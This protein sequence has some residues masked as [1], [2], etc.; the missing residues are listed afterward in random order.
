MFRFF[1]AL[2][3]HPL[4]TSGFPLINPDRTRR[5]VEQFALAFDTD[6]APIVGQQVTLTAGNAAAVGPRIALLEQRA[7]AAFTSKLLGG[8]VKECELVARL[9]QGGAIRGFLFDPASASFAP[10]GGGAALSDSA[11][12]AL[13][14]T[15]G[16]EV[17]FTC[18]P[19][20][21]GARLAAAQ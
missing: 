4:V 15:P 10:A 14:A 21:Q 18:A 3:F 6:L 13:A 1:S 17:T 20:G 16:Q 9:A 5:D 8:T 7:G 2:V 11:L 19:T 12:R